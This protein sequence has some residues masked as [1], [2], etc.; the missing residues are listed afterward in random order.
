[1]YSFLHSQPKIIDVYLVFPVQDPGKVDE[2]IASEAA[3]VL[4]NA[5]YASENVTVMLQNEGCIP[6]LVSVSQTHTVL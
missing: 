2:R 1:M 3:N 5:C 4:M 6:P